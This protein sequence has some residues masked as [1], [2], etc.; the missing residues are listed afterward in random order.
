MHVEKTLSSAILATQSVVVKQ[1]F[2]KAMAAMFG[3][4]FISY[5]AEL[6]LIC[7]MFLIDLVTGMLAAMKTKDFQSAKFFKGCTKLMVYA[8]FIMLAIGTDYI[9]SFHVL[10]M[11]ESIR[12]FLSITFSFIILTDVF[13]VFENLEKLGYTTPK[14]MFKNVLSNFKK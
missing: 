10:G 1:P 12:V 11:S 3:F 13:S 8:I 7:V 14:K 9:V 6:L 5:R 4:V 2:V